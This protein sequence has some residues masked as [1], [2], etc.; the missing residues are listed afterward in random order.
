MTDQFHFQSNL[1]CVG[2]EKKLGRVWFVVVVYHRKIRPTL[3]CVELG[4]A[5]GNGFDIIVN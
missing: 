2:A 3:L 1:G 5:T 4:V